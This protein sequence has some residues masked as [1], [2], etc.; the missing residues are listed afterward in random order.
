MA[1]YIVWFL[2]TGL[3]PDGNDAE[4]LMSELIDNGYKYLT[5]DDLR[6]IAVYLL[7]LEPLHNKVVAKEKQ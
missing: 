2:Q 4:G 3:R 1:P 6:A 5:E 7:S